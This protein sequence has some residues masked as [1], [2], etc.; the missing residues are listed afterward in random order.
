MQRGVGAEI[1]LGEVVRLVEGLVDQRHRT[2]AV[3]AVAQHL[4]DERIGYL[5]RLQVEQAAERAAGLTHQLLAFAR[6]QP[7]KPVVFDVGT[8]VENV[9]QLIRPL[10]GGSI[11]IDFTVG[12]IQVPKIDAIQ[13]TQGGT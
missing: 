13:I 11:Q 5:R 3:L 6:R 2:D 10:V 9:A 4:Q 8:Q 1:D 12:N 7:L